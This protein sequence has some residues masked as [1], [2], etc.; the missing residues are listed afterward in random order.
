MSETNNNNEAAT[1]LY[2]F[3]ARDGEEIPKNV[4]AVTI[5]PSVTEIPNRAFR[6]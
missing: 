5:H 1:Q 4:T 2:T 6:R 3:D